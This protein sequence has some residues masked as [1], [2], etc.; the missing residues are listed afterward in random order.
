MQGSKI[1]NEKR[2]RRSE[3]WKMG[4]I[5]LD[6]VRSDLQGP[7][8]VSLLPGA[9][10]FVPLLNDASGIYILMFLPH[11]N[12]DGNYFKKKIREAERFTGRTIK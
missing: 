12:Q 3:V 1:K 6:L 9:K 5:P 11:K 10:Y 4:T 7:M 8:S 2:L